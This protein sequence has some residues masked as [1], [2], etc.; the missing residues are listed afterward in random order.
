MSELPKPLGD[1]IVAVQQKA[2]IQTK[3][4]IFT[5]DVAKEQPVIADVVAIGPDVKHAKVGDK[6]VYKEYATTDLKLEDTEYLIVSEEDVLAT[7]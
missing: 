3:S 4:G 1:R 7:L 2:S 5:S 6:I